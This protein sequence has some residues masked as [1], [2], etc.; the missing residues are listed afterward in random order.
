[1]GCFNSKNIN[2]YKLIEGTKVYKTL[3][4]L[5]KFI[6]CLDENIFILYFEGKYYCKF[7]RDGGAPFVGKKVFII[8]PG[9]QE[10]PFLNFYIKIEFIVDCDNY[11][12][13]IKNIIGYDDINIYNITTN[14]E[15]WTQC[16]K[17]IT[18]FDKCVYYKY[19]NQF[20]KNIE[21][22]VMNFIVL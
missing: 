9:T 7:M 17:E 2:N 16:L 15:K 10:Q 22:N 14:E 21:P 8:Y 12:I 11:M 4:N 20:K 5:E 3:I 6:L 18:N 13:V 1:M 19:R